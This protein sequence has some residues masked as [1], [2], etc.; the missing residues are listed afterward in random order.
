MTETRSGATPLRAGHCPGEGGHPD[1]VRIQRRNVLGHPPGT[2]GEQP[3][4][5]ENGGAGSY[6]G[7]VT[8]RMPSPARVKLS[9]VAHAPETS[10]DTTTSPEAKG[11]RSTPTDLEHPTS[12]GSNIITVA[13]SSGVDH[14]T[15]LCSPVD[16]TTRVLSPLVN[17]T[18]LGNSEG[19]NADSATTSPPTPNVVRS[20][21]PSPA[22]YSTV[23]SAP[24]T[25]NG[26][27]PESNRQTEGAE[28]PAATR[29]TT[30]SDIIL[31]T[32]AHTSM[33]L[34]F[35]TSG[36]APPHLKSCS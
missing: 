10:S 19:S 1:L 6:S 29:P 7:A 22:P 3:A 25:A 9:T 28:Q 21:D 2:D 26:T 24:P 30:A 23:H 13:G 8:V 12:T 31:L 35:T 4:G 11:R 14:P 18:K 27:T 34:T 15:A 33:S 17:P 32:V 36:R 16:A 20:V 5:F